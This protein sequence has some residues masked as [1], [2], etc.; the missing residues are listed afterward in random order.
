MIKKFLG[1]VAM[2]LLLVGCAKNIEIKIVDTSDSTPVTVSNFFDYA[3]IC[4]DFN[5]RIVIDRNTGVLYY[6]RKMGYGSV[7]VAIIDKDGKP[8]TFAK[9]KENR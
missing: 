4:S 8:L 3:T 1:I 9:W 5:E 6:Y 7:M 2:T